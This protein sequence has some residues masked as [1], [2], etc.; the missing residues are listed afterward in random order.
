MLLVIGPVILLAPLIAWHYRLANTKSA[1]RPQWGFSWLLEGL[2]WIPPSDHRHH[3]R[4][5]PCSRERSSLIPTV[6]IP[7]ALAT[8]PSRCRCARLEVALHLSRSSTLP[9]VNQL[10]VPAGRPVHMRLTSGTVMQSL[11]MPR[12]AGQIYAMAGMVTQLNRLDFA[13]PGNL[14][15]RERAQYN[16]DGFVREKFQIY[17][18]D[19]SGLSTTGLRV[20]S[21]RRPLSTTRLT[22]IFRRSRRSS[23]PDHLRH[24]RTRHLHEDRSPGDPSRLCGSSMTTPNLM[25]NR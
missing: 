1:F 3:P 14:L 25:G 13:R 9:R 11:L 5:L 12:L 24:C 2:I 18:R 17:G 22:T 10:I 6:P 15:G 16:G 4:R 23:P 8:A 21:R 7:S 19:A 20:C